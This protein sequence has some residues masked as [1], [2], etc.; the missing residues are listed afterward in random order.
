M[1][2]VATTLLPWLRKILGKGSLA[3]LTSGD[4]EALHA[5]ASLVPLIGYNHPVPQDIVSAFTA[6]VHRMQ[7]HTRHLAYH[8]I[9]H[10]LDW[11]DRDRIWNMTGLPPIS[12]THRQ[13]IP[14]LS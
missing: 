10:T 9:A 6:C 2:P 4:T 13:L 11:P 8:S 14:A 5:A 12:I 7:P 1:K 3:P